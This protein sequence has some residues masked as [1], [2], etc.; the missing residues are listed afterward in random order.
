MVFAL[1][2][3]VTTGTS[4][5]SFGGAF[6]PLSG[7]STLSAFLL[8]TLPFVAFVGVSKAGGFS[9][10]SGFFAATSTVLIGASIVDCVFAIGALL[11]DFVGVAG[12][13]LTCAAGAV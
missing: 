11:G 10:D 13:A 3:A 9:L 5:L 8:A 1:E 2:D 4:A 12:T 7:F 6:E